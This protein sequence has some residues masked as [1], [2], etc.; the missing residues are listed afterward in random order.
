MGDA[1]IDGLFDLAQTN[2]VMP[3]V[4]RTARFNQH[5]NLIVSLLKHAP[6]RRLLVKEFASRVVVSALG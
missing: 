6:A 2:G 5:R 3:I 1:E 4:R